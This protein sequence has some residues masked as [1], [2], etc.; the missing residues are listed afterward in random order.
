MTPNRKLLALL[1]IVWCP[2]ANAQDPVEGKDDE[3]CRS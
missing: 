1:L 3:P 2:L